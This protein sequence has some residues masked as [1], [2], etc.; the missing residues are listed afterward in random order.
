MVLPAPYQRLCL[1]AVGNV[2]AWLYSWQTQGRFGAVLWI[3]LGY[4]WKALN[5][6]LVLIQNPGFYVGIICC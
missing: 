2:L 5:T 4:R 1:D 3:P 6:M